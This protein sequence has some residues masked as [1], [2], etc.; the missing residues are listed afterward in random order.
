MMVG[1]YVTEYVNGTKHWVAPNTTNL[2]PPP[3]ESHAQV[4]AAT[5]EAFEAGSLVGW[6]DR[7]LG[8]GGTAPTAED[9]GVLALPAP[10]PTLLD[11]NAFESA[12]ELE[13]AGVCVCG[14]GGV[15]LRLP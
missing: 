11:L 4:A 8:S 12:E 15:T 13:S 10:A 1:M 2:A 14:G 6:E 3:S 5:Q 9:G 7:G